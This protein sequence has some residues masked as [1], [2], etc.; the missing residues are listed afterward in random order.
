MIQVIFMMLCICP[1]SVAAL[2]LQH[3]TDQNHDHDG[4]HL[5][6]GRHQ[7]PGRVHRG[8]HGARGGARR[9]AQGPREVGAH[10]GAPVHEQ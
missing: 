4:W 7:Q 10:G 8:A 1:P 5:Q 9:E 2:H 3:L 6:R